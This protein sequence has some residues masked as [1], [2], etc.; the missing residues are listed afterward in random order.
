MFFENKKIKNVFF[1]NFLFSEF[2][3]IF[4]R[5]AIAIDEKASKSRKFIKRSVNI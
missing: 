1:L 2:P 3:V 4:L 5:I